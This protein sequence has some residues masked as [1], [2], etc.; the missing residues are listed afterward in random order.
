MSV[1]Q[2]QM[3]TSYANETRLEATHRRT[4]RIGTAGDSWSSQRASGERRLCD[5]LCTAG[6]LWLQMAVLERSQRKP[7]AS[8]AN[9]RLALGSPST[10][11]IVGK[12]GAAGEAIHVGAYISSVTVSKKVRLL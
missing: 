10:W 6:S 9:Q 3:S 11:A 8:T 4:R 7:T 12:L 5:S 1:L 2:M